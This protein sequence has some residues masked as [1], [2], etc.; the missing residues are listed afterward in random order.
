MPHLNLCYDYNKIC[1]VSGMKIGLVSQLANAIFTQF[2]FTE[3]SQRCSHELNA[4]GWMVSKA[5]KR[6]KLK[7]S[8]NLGNLSEVPYTYVSTRNI[9]PTCKLDLSTPM[10]K[11]KPKKKSA[12]REMLKWRKCNHYPH[13]H[14][15][16]YY[17]LKLW[18]TSRSNYFW[19]Q[20]LLMWINSYVKMV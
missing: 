15:T 3:T 5:L 10:K 11:Q 19:V 2:Y 8:I 16:R 7:T 14:C 1:S 6:V 20:P 9:H 18:W 12:S 13:P 17:T 4:G